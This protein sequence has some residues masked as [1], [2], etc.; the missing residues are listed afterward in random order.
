MVNGLQERRVS[1]SCLGQVLGRA[2]DDGLDLLDRHACAQRRDEARFAG[3]IGCAMQELQVEVVHDLRS[4]FRALFDR[5]HDLSAASASTQPIHPAGQ[6][7]GIHLA[8][9]QLPVDHRDE[10]GVGAAE[11]VR[12]R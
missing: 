2:E 10:D 11:C 4:V 6:A 5:L 1:S 12:R 3:A 8:A 9:E 7:R